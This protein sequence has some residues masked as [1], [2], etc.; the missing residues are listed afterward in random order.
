MTIKLIKFIYLASM[1]ALGMYLTKQAIVIL[2]SEDD[3]DTAPN[4]YA[5]ETD[6]F[7]LNRIKVEVSE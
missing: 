1:L 4:D 7:D 2:E 5:L 6:Q 3:I